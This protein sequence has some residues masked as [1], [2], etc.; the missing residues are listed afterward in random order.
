MVSFLGFLDHL[1]LPHPLDDEDDAEETKNGPTNHGTKD[2]RLVKE[3]NVI[4]VSIK[5]P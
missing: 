3:R 5:S 4:L 2:L 1:F